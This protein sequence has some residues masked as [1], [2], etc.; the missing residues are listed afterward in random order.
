MEQLKRLIGEIHRR[1]LWQV[2]G[3]YIIGSWIAL[4][5][6]ETL[7]SSLG[8]PEWFPSLA[9]VLLIVGLPIVLATAFIQEGVPPVRTPAEDPAVSEGSGAAE[10]DPAD[11]SS[12]PTVRRLF[13]WRNA[14]MGGVVAFAL[15]GVVAAG[16]LLFG[17]GGAIPGA[18]AEADAESDARPMLVVLP[19]ENLGAPEDEYFA[20]GITEEITSRLAAIT[21]LG[22]ISRTSAV[23]YKNTDK[24]VQAIG[25]ELGVDYL[26]E[27]TIRWQRAPD[28]ASRVRVTPQ[29]IRVRDDTHLWA[30]RYDAVL[31]DIFEVQTTIAREVIESLD[32]ALFEQFEQQEGSI[33][34]RPT[35]SLEAYDYYL[36]GND[37][38][39]R[40]DFA[41]A[42]EMYR[43]AVE[44][45]P[46]FAIA[47]SKLS[48]SHVG[49]YWFGA[50][51]SEERLARS[52]AAMN[53]ALGLDP[54]LPEAHLAKGYHH[55][56]GQLDYRSAIN[57]FERARDLG[58]RNSDLFHA[59][60]AVQRRQGE[61][62]AS[63]ASFAKAAEL[64]PRSGHMEN[65]L[66]QTLRY[67]RRF[68]EAAE[69]AER[70][71]ALAPDETSGY[72]TLASIRLDWKG[73]LESAAHV[74]R[75]AE[76][77]ADA[78][79]LR[80]HRYLIDLLQR[81]F[82]AARS[83]LR[84]DGD[85]ADYYL[86]M[87]F[88]FRAAG[89]SA[90]AGVYYD[91]ARTVLEAELSG[92]PEDRQSAGAYSDLGLAYAGLGR[93]EDATRA[94]RRARDLLS[95]KDD[96]LA[97]TGP[98]RDLARIYTYVGEYKAAIDLLERL[99]SLP[100]DVT[101]TQLRIHPEWDPLRRHPRFQKLVETT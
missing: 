66:A 8:L 70:A 21:G 53:R 25:Q 45:D 83:H 94:G 19:F 35:A 85:T 33:D 46:R 9:V 41:I 38:Y 11:P 5:V 72:A 27:G 99:L 69:H 48:I 40:L 49:Q 50:D 55:Y 64:D 97:G 96:A 65:D 77:K 93:K 62:Q 42:E 89:D 88:T 12:R 90:N 84:P 30:D 10:P 52:E 87:A 15:W 44:L 82:S 95:L 80:W 32:V 67:M 47:W 18:S 101:R 23:Q 100:G 24:S 16:W 7:T 61:W 37:Y 79:Y 57:E 86:G 31:E 14:I 43:K 22:V 60:A 34:G 59:L 75:E 56:W 58:L 71:I 2:L 68:A 73:D 17:G 51:R 1:S 29:L 63:A 26:L 6:V 98:I 3:I 76:R 36:R 74:L 92:A 4:Q 54:D 13:R 78:P 91:S 28:Q 20:D 81:D 39:N